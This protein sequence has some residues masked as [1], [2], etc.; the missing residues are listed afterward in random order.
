MELICCRR[1]DKGLHKSL[2]CYIH[3]RPCKRRSWAI[4]GLG[5]KVSYMMGFHFPYIWQSWRL[6]AGEMAENTGLCMAV[7]TADI[8]VSK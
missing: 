6:A 3:M 1:R 5:V 7:L 8:E 4:R 2:V